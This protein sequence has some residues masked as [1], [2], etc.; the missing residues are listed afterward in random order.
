[1]EEIEN[2][3]V[4]IINQQLEVC[5]TNKIAP[6]KEVLDTIGSLIMIRSV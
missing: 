2:N 1:M 5:K 3:L 6:S 4:E